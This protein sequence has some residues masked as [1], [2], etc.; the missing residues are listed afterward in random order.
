MQ[1]QQAIHW[2]SVSARPVFH[3]ELGEFFEELRLQ[4]GWNQRQAAAP[5]DLPLDSCEQCGWCSRSILNVFEQHAQVHQRLAR[6]A[7]AEHV[8]DVIALLMKSQQ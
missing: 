6:Q 4:R 3:K 8:G 2:R 7:L 5:V 1:T